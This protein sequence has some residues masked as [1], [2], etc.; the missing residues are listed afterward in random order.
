MCNSLSA[1][2]GT[3]LADGNQVVHA[4]VVHRYIHP[5]VSGSGIQNMHTYTDPSPD[6]LQLD[7][8]WI[9]TPNFHHR[10][11]RPLTHDRTNVSHIPN[12]PNAFGRLGQIPNVFPRLRLK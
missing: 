3:S 4:G 1:V 5:H 7:P 2:T 9:V 12:L 6:S 11:P 8:R 10:L